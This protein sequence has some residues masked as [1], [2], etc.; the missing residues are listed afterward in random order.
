M[1][2]GDLF[3]G[4]LGSEVELTRWSRKITPVPVE[5]TKSAD[6]SDGTLLE[7]VVTRYTN[8]TIAYETMSGVD[9]EAIEALYN[10]GQYLNFFVVGRDGT[11]KDEGLYKMTWT[12]GNMDT[13]GK[14][15]WNGVSIN[16]RRVDPNEG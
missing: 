3:L 14:W 10:L 13:A 12:P 7:D 1:K 6:A 4:S 9:H 2:P 8:Y 16:L 15:R 11:K 5:I